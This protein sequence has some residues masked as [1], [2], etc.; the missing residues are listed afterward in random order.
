MGMYTMLSLDAVVKLT[1]DRA[2]LLEAMCNKGAFD[3]IPDH[4]FFKNEW[5]NWREFLW[6]DGG[7]GFRPPYIKKTSYDDDTYVFSICISLKNYYNNIEEFLD[8][9]TTDPSIKVRVM[10][11]YTLYEEDDWPTLFK[12]D[13]W[14]EG[15][16][17]EY[18]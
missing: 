8:W 15:A 13:G 18:K 3:A 17:I 2:T 16:H 12:Y 5:I 7:Y 11:G 6:Y 14:K 9:L 4:P 10:I 1:K